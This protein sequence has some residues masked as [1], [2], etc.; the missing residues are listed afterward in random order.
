MI[1]RSFEHQVLGILGGNTLAD[2]RVV[3][4]AGNGAEL[5]PAIAIICDSVGQIDLGWIEQTN[6]LRNS[7]FASVAPV[8][9][10]AAAYR[11]LS[12]LAL[13]LPLFD[14]DGMM[15]ELSGY[16][17]DG[18]TTDEGARHSL[19]E[20]FGQ[21]PEEL[22]LPSHIEARRPDFMLAENAAPMKALPA[23][24]RAKLRRLSAAHDALKEHWRQGNAWFFERSEVSDYLPEYEDASYLPPMTT[25]PFDA[26]AQELD[27]VGRIGMETAFF[28]IAGLCPLPEADAIERWFAT[29]R[30]G[31]ELIAAAQDLID[32][33]PAEV[34]R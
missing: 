30:L 26:F 4:L 3:V 17:W 28:N 21:D 31:A 1:E 33:N 12:K 23:S 32:F 25:V 20:Y 34:L 24:L 5:P 2:L 16:Y 7:L 27:E 11:S 19:V 8:G 9:W 22:T 18:E 29:L 14:F 10:R 13:V 6:V 15:E